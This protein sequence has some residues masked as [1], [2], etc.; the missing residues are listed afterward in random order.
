[1][2]QARRSPLLLLGLDAADLGMIETHRASLP[3]LRRVLDSAAVA[4][5]EST[6]DLLT[7]SVWPTFATGLLPGEHGVYHHL[8]W[9]AAAMRLRRV[10][11]DWLDWQPFWVELEQH[12]LDVAVLDVPMAYP[13]RL[14]RGVEITN[15][16]SHDRLGPFAAMP[17]SIAS[18]VRR[19]FSRSHPMGAE[20]P[21]DKT[22][23]QLERIRR[24]LV[25]GAARKGEL[26]CWLLAQRLGCLP[27]RAWRTHRVPHSLARRSRSFV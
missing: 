13:G 19:R 8:Q 9:D 15:W 1:M 23:E 18:Q 2:K 27:C 22:P 12:G 5:L 11:A 21:V 4:R 25:V 16:G 26:A 17:A 3:T 6:A 10:A 14:T 20:I 24:G 7:G